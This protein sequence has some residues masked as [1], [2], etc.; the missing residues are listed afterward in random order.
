MRLAT[1]YRGLEE[2]DAVDDDADEEDVGGGV[3]S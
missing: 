1:E 3:W 2:G